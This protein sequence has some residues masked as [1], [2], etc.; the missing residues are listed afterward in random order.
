MKI[1]ASFCISSEVFYFRFIC[2][3][4]HRRSSR[5]FSLYLKSIQIQGRGQDITLSF[6]KDSISGFRGNDINF[7]CV[8]ELTFV[9][10][11]MGAT[12]QTF[13]ALRVLIIE[14]LPT[15]G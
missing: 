8:F 5:V 6:L 15:L 13:L 10:P 9:S 11:A 14:L 2:S 1:F 3:A 12:L 4:P 7:D